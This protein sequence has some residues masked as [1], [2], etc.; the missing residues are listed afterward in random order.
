MTQKDR[1]KSHKS[2]PSR[3]LIIGAG[4]GAAA[5][6]AWWTWPKIAPYLVGEFTFAPLPGMPGFRRISGGE[7]SGN[8]NPLAGID[9]PAQADRASLKEDVRANICD[10]LFGGTAAEGV[11]PIASFSDYYCPFCRVLTQKLDALEQAEDGSVKVT[12]HEWPLLGTNSELA[13][14][15]AL[16]ADRQGAYVA[17]HKRLMRTSF[18]ATPDFLEALAKSIGIEPNRMRADIY[19]DAVSERLRTSAAIAEVFGFRGTP[20][21]VVGRTVVVGA[22]SDA[23]IKALIDQE[24]RDGPLAF[25]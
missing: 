15:A 14:R 23:T 6:A 2:F 8:I 12:W 16:A 18:V 10:A 3:R 5:A 21:L 11:V 20:A 24:R 9:Q 13:A 17:F 25:C 22:V 19:S 1:S 4:L 7:T